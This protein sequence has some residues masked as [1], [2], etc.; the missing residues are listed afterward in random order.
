MSLI[1]ELE[2]EL[3]RNCRLNNWDLGFQAAIDI[4]KQHNEWVSVNERLPKPKQEVLIEV[5][6]K[7]RIAIFLGKAEDGD[8][9]LFD[10][11]FREDE[12]FAYQYVCD[13]SHQV[14]HWQP[15]PQPTSE[16]QNG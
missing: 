2:K 3:A 16:V 7:T 8:E 11:D 15:L 6:G 1:K 10:Y 5:G 13:T 9:L 12:E 14:T 4:V